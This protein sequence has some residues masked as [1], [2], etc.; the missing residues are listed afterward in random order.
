MS[1]KVLI[2]FKNNK[3][4]MQG[5]PPDRAAGHSG[6]LL[7]LKAGGFLKALDERRLIIVSVQRRPAAAPTAGGG[8]GHISCGVRQREER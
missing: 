4:N 2:T 6:K 1:I 7:K 3:N 5:H 8:E